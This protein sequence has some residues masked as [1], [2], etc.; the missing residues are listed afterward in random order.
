MKANSWDSPGKEGGNREDIGGELSIIQPMET[1]FTSMVKKTTCSSTNPEV[2][3]DEIRKPRTGGAK[4]G[5]GSD[6]TGNKASGR[7]RFGGRVWKC[8]DQWAVT[9]VQAAIARRGGNAFVD[10]EISIAQVRTM[11]AMK[12]DMEATNLGL[13]EGAGGSDDDMRTR[14]FFKWVQ[15]GAQA[16]DPVPPQFRTPAA[17]IITLDLSDGEVLSES[18]T[19]ASAGAGTPAYKSFN[20]LLKSM[21]QAYGHKVNAVAFAG[22]DIIEMV[23]NFTRSDG[24]GNNTRYTVQEG[25]NTHEISLYV[26]VFDTSFARVE[27]VPDQFVAYD[28]VTQLGNPKAAAIAVM[29]YWEN[30]YLEEMVSEENPDRSGGRSGWAR[31][32]YANICRNPKGQGAILTQA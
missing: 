27:M 25:E 26:T 22:D 7:R 14:G 16:I 4:E 23:D 17:S 24:A 1:P 10:D 8:T 6:G 11:A 5:K 32:M 3:A 20:A 19:L 9:D 28:E 30:Q 18:K 31:C 21:K 2:G 12:T 29:E 15:N 13:Q